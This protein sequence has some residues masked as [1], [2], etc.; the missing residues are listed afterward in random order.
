MTALTATPWG[1]GAA[2]YDR[3]DGAVYDDG[4]LRVEHD[5][6]FASL[7]GRA[8]TMTRK[9]FLIL[10]R[11]ARNPDR[12]VSSDELWRHAW[13]PRAPL[14]AESLHVHVYRLRRKLDPTG[15]RIETMVNVG[16]RL[17]TEAGAAQ[18]PRADRG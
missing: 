11:L 6:Y 9:E 17:M 14:N 10:S 1:D 4:N 3:E 16:Y 12:V 2:R 5:N 15:P 13:G 8:L 18:G 7:G